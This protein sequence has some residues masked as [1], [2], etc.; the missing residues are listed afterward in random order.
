[1]NRW[2]EFVDRQ[3]ELAEA[4]PHCCISSASAWPSLPP[5][6]GTAD[7]GCTPCAIHRRQRL[8]SYPCADNDDEFY[9]TGRAVFQSD[10]KSI[11]QLRTAFLA[12]REW[13]DRPPPGWSEQEV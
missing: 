1:M 5:F 2:Q 10:P 12:E 13:T 9:I 7:R 3:P 4:G 8:H 11:D 6:V